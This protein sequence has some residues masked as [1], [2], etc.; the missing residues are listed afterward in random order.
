M[1][2]HTKQY[3]QKLLQPDSKDS[4][5]S[6][7]MFASVLCGIFMTLCLGFSLCWDTV[8]DGRF[9]GDLYGMAAETVA[10]G[11]MVSLSSIP[12]AWVDKTKAAK[13]TTPAA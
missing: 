5:K 7:S 12:K 13:R 1:F 3:L 10:I 9:D 8:Q 2:T 4:V 6:F 11:A